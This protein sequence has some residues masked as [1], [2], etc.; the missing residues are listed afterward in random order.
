MTILNKIRQLTT[1]VLLSILLL[2]GMAWGQS[3]TLSSAAFGMQCGPG[4]PT[5]CP[6]PITLP[7]EPGTLRLWDSEVE[8]SAINT[9]NGTYN[10]ATLNDY[11]YAIASDS[12]LK[13][14][15]YTFGW[16]PC[17]DAVS[18]SDPSQNR[19]STPPED[20]GT[21]TCGTGG[22]GSCT[23]DAFVQALTTYCAPPTSQFPNGVCFASVVKYFELW[24][25][26]NSTGFWNG[27][28]SQL[29][30]MV[31]PAV[32]IIK[33]NVSGAKF[34]TPSATPTGGEAWMADS[35]LPEEVSNGV[36][37]NFYNFHVYL[38]T[39]TPETRWEDVVQQ[40]I[41]GGGHGLLYPNYNT[42]GWTPLP[43]LVSETNFIPTGTLS[44]TCS[45]SFSQADCT[46]QVVRWQAILNSNGALNLS[47]YYW[48]TTIGDKGEPSHP[49]ATAYYWMMQ[50]MVN[51]FF[52]AA[53]QVSGVTWTCPFKEGDEVNALFVWTTSE[54]N[55]NY[56]VPPGYVDYRDLNGGT[57]SVTGGEQITITVEPIMLEQM[58]PRT[59]H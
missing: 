49:Y 11:L 6:I 55:T 52:S 15:I 18:C 37:S 44:F 54:N 23:F 25:E 2:A 19:T 36:L 48:N 13:N 59:H 30:H 9:A 24:N 53:C 33:K 8:W 16:V 47:W 14:V 57:T 26:A 38:D 32:G 27:T 41:T 50:Y 56:T 43:W 10:F 45:T 4:K 58:K 3:G 51:G 1:R 22:T 12:S 5:N 20:L 39:D 29:Y 7:T 42:T 46:G 21:G 17:W 28:A 40:N 31:A 34:L 35:W